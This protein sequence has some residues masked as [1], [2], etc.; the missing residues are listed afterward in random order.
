MDIRFWPY[1]GLAACFT[2]LK[3]IQWSSFTTKIWL[4]IIFVTFFTTFIA[5]ILNVY[6][7]NALSPSVVS[8]YIYL[9]PLMT[10][11]LAIT[12]GNDVIN[13]MKFLPQ[14]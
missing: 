1:T 4:Y 12:T 8:A 2:D 3:G 14:C 7:L 9:Q 13:G 10:A 6:S 11:I 5:Y